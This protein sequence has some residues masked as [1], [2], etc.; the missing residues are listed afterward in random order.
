MSA[1]ISECGMYRYWLERDL[2]LTGIVVAYFGVNPSTADATIPDQTDMKWRGFGKLLGARKYIAG[3]PFAF[4]STDVKALARAADPVGP[5]NDAYLARIIADADMLVPCWGP[6]TKVP[7]SLRYR[8]DEVETMLRDSGKPL[9]TFGFSKSGDPL[10][11]LMLAYNTTLV[12]W[13]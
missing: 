8:Y 10:H 12:D 4:R 7:R 1:I 6:R 13:K 2:A 3:N 5:E 11:P 9:K